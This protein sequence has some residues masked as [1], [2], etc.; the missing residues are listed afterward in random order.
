MYGLRFPPDFVEFLSASRPMETYD[1]SIDNPAIWQMLNWPAEGLIFDVEHNALWLA[2]WGPRP[3]IPEARAE[4]VRAVVH[5]APPLIPVYSHRYIPAEPNEAGN[6]V[7]SVYQ[8]DI[9]VYGFNLKDYVGRETGHCDEVEWP[10]QIK[11]IRFWS[12]LVELNNQPPSV[13]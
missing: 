5:E 10:D 1:W 13:C 3:E 8:A 4:V 6:P 11:H 12:H 9:I 2:D 7:F